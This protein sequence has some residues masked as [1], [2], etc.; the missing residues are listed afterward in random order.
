[1]CPIRAASRPEAFTRFQAALRAVQPAGFIMSYVLSDDERAMVVQALGRVGQ[2][3][4]AERARA[5]KAVLMK[6]WAM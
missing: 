2:A 1:M 6:R 3:P 4:T 5:A